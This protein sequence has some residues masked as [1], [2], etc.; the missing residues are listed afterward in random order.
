MLH[1]PNRAERDILVQDRNQSVG[2]GSRE[3]IARKIDFRQDLVRAE[4][5]AQLQPKGV[6]E[7]VARQ[8]HIRQGDR[9]VQRL[10]YFNA[11]RVVQVAEPQVQVCEVL[12]P[13][14]RR[15]NSNN[16]CQK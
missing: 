3:A 16:M 15:S 5:L 12:R 6:R 13:A 8:V 11:V 14:E 9:C 4:D 1:V 2:E 7:L 10:G